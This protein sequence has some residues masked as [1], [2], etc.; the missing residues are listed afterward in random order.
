M[1]GRE[2]AA[3][4]SEAGRDRLAHWSDRAR[5]WADSPRARRLRLRRRPA[6]IAAGVLVAGMGLVLVDL[7]LVTPS[8]REI[9]GLAQMPVATT[10]FDRHD[11]HAFAIFQERRLEVPLDQVSPHLVEAVLAIEDQRFYEH[12]G[13][14]L[15]RIGGAAVA[16]LR[17]AEWA[18]GGSTITQQLARLSFL[19]PEKSLRRKMKEALL[20]VRIEWLFD[21]DEI[22]EV[23]L[24]KVYFGAGF[25]GAEAAAR[26]YFGKPAAA[27]HIEEAALLAGLIQAP[28]AYAPTSH[29]PRAIDRRAVVLDQMAQAGFIERRVAEALAGAPV[30]LVN[31]FG[32]E[33][34]GAYFKQEVARQLIE[35]FG[36]D[37]VSKGGLRVFTTFDPVAQ[38]AAEQAL[39][40]G[41]SDV[42]QRAAFRHGVRGDGTAVEGA[43][44]AYL[45]GALVAV[46]PTNGEVRAL[47]G[48]RDFGESQFDRATQARRQSGSAFKPFI[49]AA[50]LEMGY[51]PA[52]LV[53]GLDQPVLTPEGWWVPNDGHAD[54]TAMTVRTALRTSSNR[55]AVQVLQAVGIGQAVNYVE[56]MGLTAPAV[57]SLVLG[58]GDVTL[59][60]LTI[61]YGAFANGGLLREPILIRRV[62]DARGQVL[63][64]A[65]EAS[66]RVV[67]EQ[68]AFLM[69]Q[70]LADVVDR[71]TGYRARRA[72]F[73]L[74][75][76]GKTGTTNDY[77]DAWFVGFTPDL[78]AGVW[79]GFDQ[80]Q[81]IVAN[82]YA[83]ELAV[84]IWGAFMRDATKG[85]EDR[86][87]DRPDGIVA[88]EICR[89]SGLRPGS[90]CTRVRQVSEDGD[91]T[92]V[93][94]VGVEYFS[95]GTEPHQVCPLHEYSWFSGSSSNALDPA[96]FPASAMIGTPPARETRSAEEKAEKADE[97]KPDDEK[98]GFW[99]RF[100]G[101][102]SGGGGD[103][104]KKPGAGAGS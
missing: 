35:R 8:A 42:E 31:G 18:Q 41:L 104:K 75:A 11:D 7:V 56:R 25:Y 22:L 95:R 73:T 14:D 62:E 1:V 34:I 74:P 4:W 50:A 23:Y 3:R 92:N 101:V 43:A 59:L 52:T 5:Q 28:S 66:R 99:S 77:H 69:A 63:M 6:A 9:R 85:A 65:Q 70:M 100:L 97:D 89:E 38:R 29:L 82:G 80:P 12:N 13:L 103:E 83:G 72:G 102:F 86:W 40:D 51:S 33:D 2:H 60:S 71:G 21:K 67:S 55:A 30:G 37:V 49:Y 39:A 24:N 15:W 36:W 78:V 26:G 94:M 84:P 47:V 61:A 46:D 27:L 32:R 10:V 16:N 81:P 93:S 88:V 87:V 48:G 17:D 98:K 57:P 68:T 44:P 20:A 90:A 79:L 91:V 76:A 64:S 19:T 96:E 53:T 58:S 54:A 45:Q